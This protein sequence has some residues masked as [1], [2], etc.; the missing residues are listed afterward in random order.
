MRACHPLEH[1][2]LQWTE[3]SCNGCSL[4][5]TVQCVPQGEMGRSR[6]VG[7]NKF[8]MS[9]AD[10]HNKVHLCCLHEALAAAMP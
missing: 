6:G 10:L 4:R 2:L 5:I 1:A 7:M 9:K 8:K 3:D